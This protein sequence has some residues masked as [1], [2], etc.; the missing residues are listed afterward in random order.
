MFLRRLLSTRLRRV[1]FALVLL[2]ALLGF[3]GWYA[4]FRVVPVYYASPEE[5]FKYG[6][7]GVEVPAGIPYWIWVEM[8]KVFPD[9]LPNNGEGGYVSLGAS[10]EDGKE[11]PIG[12]TKMTVGFPRVGV[13]CAGCHTTSV[14]TST[15]DKP[16]F[17]LGGPSAR[18]RAQDYLRFLFACA[19]DPRFNA[20]TLM[21]KINNDYNLNIVDRILYRYIIIPQTKAQL[22]KTEQDSYYWMAE[23]PDWGPGRTDMDPFKLLV[24]GLPDD[25][26]VGSTDMMPVWNERASETYLRH[27]DGL[28]T[29][30]VESVRSAAL[31]A[32]ATKKSI[33]I[34]GLDRVQQYLMDLPVPKYPFAVN[35]QLT[36]RGREVFDRDCAVCHAPGSAR[37]GK[38]IPLEE[39]G[40]DPNRNRHWTPAAADAFNHYAPEKP[41]A[42][43]NFQSTN[44][45]TARSLEGLWLRA[46]YL[47]NGS[48]PSLVD[49]LKPPD[50]RPKLFY[51]GHDVYDQENVGFVSFGPEAE[52][53]G[54]KY[55]T[56]NV[57]GNGNWGHTWGTALSADDKKAL[58]EYLKTL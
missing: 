3:A 20:D 48:V 23:R 38:V 25:H 32:A 46:P 42:F 33:D 1:V 9:L 39:L 51:R 34:E 4:L 19:K 8:P 7:I 57:I 24:L 50:E 37:I 36:A 58:T 29:T 5:H 49:L 22:I 41:W 35:E 10:W 18:F 54:W 53:Y 40:T 30:L 47:H 55:D 15:S 28:N 6:S 16:K 27:S 11:M 31:A 21:A 13:N 45:Y 14:R 2:V 56:V 43:H 44:G 17:Y 52:K 12:F 26:T